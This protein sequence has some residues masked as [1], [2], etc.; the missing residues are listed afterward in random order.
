MDVSQAAVSDWERGAKLD[1]VRLGEIAEALG[2]TL[3]AL[4]APVDEPDEARG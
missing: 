2:T 3:I 1:H 4:V